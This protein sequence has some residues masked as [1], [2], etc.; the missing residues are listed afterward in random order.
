KSEHGFLIGIWGPVVRRPISGGYHVYRDRRELVALPG[1]LDTN[2]HKSLEMVLELHSHLVVLRVTV[3]EVVGRPV[4]DDEPRPRAVVVRSHRL[5]PRR[6]D[7][8]ASHGRGEE[9]AGS[10][11]RR[12]R[13]LP[14]V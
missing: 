6:D 9:E 8:V 11:G 10:A 12:L 3:V 2:V 1:A 13:L 7:V 5:H 14:R 4:I